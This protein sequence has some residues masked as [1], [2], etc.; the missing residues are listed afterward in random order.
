MISIGLLENLALEVE[1][2]FAPV[3]DLVFEQ[4]TLLQGAFG[5]LF[6]A[7]GHPIEK[8]QIFDDFLHQSTFGLVFWQMRVGVQ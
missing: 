8:G 6:E 2:F 7:F 3:E 1:E 4:F 5:L